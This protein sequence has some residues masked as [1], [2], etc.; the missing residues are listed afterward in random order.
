MTNKLFER[1]FRTNYKIPI[2]TITL[3]FV[4]ITSTISI[5]FF[6]IFHIES[7]KIPQ[8]YFYRWRSIPFYKKT[9]TFMSYVSNSHDIDHIYFQKIRA[10]ARGGGTANY[11]KHNFT[12]ELP[13]KHQL[14]GLQKED[15]WILDA[16][17]LEKSFM[18]SKISFDLFKS[19]NSSHKAPECKYLEVYKNFQY[20]GLYILLERMDKKRLEINKNDNTACI[21]KEPPVFVDPKIE[22]NSNPYE[23][24]DFYHQKFP[25]KLIKNKS[26]EIQNIREFIAYSSDSIFNNK[27]TSYFDLDDIIDWHILLLFTHN[28]DGIKK[29]FYLYK[30]DKNSPFKLALWDYDCSFGRD[31]DNEPHKA[32]IMDLNQNTL[33]RRLLSLNTR[34]YK[35]RLKKRFK[36]LREKEILCEKSILKMIN[37]NYLTLKPF[38][39]SNE[40]I[41]PVFSKEFYDNANFEDEIKSIK[42]WIPVQLKEMDK[43]FNEL[44]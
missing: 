9:V 40:K 28:S 8:I 11:A 34:K 26:K 13:K 3:V 42:R 14:A 6:K 7:T 2:F 21:F 27:I 43:Y 16:S 33:I 19:F 31:S 38:I 41:W 10:K 23:E 24:N 30:K 4:I 18:R 35:F 37:E 36:L 25:D 39:S 15:D 22:I 44:K 5:S 32:E 20:R 29:G 1:K 17:F 12:I